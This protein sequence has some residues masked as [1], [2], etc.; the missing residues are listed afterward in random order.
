MDELQ[1]YL[2]IAELAGKFLKGEI[3]SE[4][5]TRLDAWVTQDHRNRILWE[6]LTR[7]SYVQQQLDGFKE[8]DPGIAWQKLLSA[9]RSAPEDAV[10][11]EPE[12]AAAERTT[13]PRRP[14]L[15]LARYAA[16][17]A[18]LAAIAIFAY[19]REAP[20]PAPA[21]IAA[22]TLD[23]IHPGAAKAQ[24]VLGNGRVLALGGNKKDTIRE[25]DGSQAATTK[26]ELK[27]ANAGANLNENAEFNSMITPRGGEYELVLSDGTKVWLNAASSIRYPTRFTGRERKVWLEGE[28]YLEV[29][30]D[31][32]HPFIIETPRTE[33]TVL[34]TCFNIKSYKDEPY[35]RTSLVDGSVKV[36]TV[37][38]QSGMQATV[39]TGQKIES[40]DADLEEALAWR[41][42]LFVFEH[43]P[44]ESI[45]RKLS[46]WY[47]VDF[48]FEDP[49]YKSLRFTGRVKRDDHITG[50]LRMLE[51]TYRVT[52]EQSGLTLTVKGQ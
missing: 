11:G 28:A 42:G 7:E 46:R 43:E 14:M 16:A 10:P 30:R 3:S 25:D 17:A 47:N 19:R 2:D 29:A 9:I 33:V 6:N 22:K 8:G 24:L 13:P 40:G 39:T 20:H 5:W 50:L 45:C 4:E 15:A 18:I 21:P 26:T 38:L 41:N 35:E 34:G 27:Y 1:S 52:F 44:L 31:A 51:S 36:G 23:D 48:R 32:A 37:V 49:K 12:P